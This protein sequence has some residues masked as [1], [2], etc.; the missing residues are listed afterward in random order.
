MTSTD[1]FTLTTRFKEAVDSL[2]AITSPKFALVLSK[3]LTSVA[4]KTP[5]FSEAEEEQLVSVLNLVTDIYRPIA[6]SPR[7]TDPKGQ[8]RSR[9]RALGRQLVH[10][11]TGGLL[12][13]LAH[14]RVASND[15]LIASQLFSSFFFFA[16][17]CARRAAGQGVVGKD[18][19]RAV[20]CVLDRVGVAHL[21]ARAPA[22]HCALVVD[23]QFLVRLLSVWLSCL[24]LTLF[25]KAFGFAHVAL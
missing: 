11:R 10:F 2:N 19:A 8:R 14:V 21:G 9:A 12:P 1:V 4:T 18:A 15:S 7:L 24:C 16:G 17:Q 20:C 13:T 22:Q 6:H 23:R 5:A 25:V 3:L